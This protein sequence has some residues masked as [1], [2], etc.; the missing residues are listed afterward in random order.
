MKY[1]P[2]VFLAAF[3][4]LASSWCGLVLAP[5]L[6]LG[7]TTQTNAVGSVDLY[8]T[9]LPGLAHQGLEVYRANGCVYCH[10]QQ[11]TQDGADCELV[12]LAAGTNQPATIAAL[13]NVKP[14]LDDA[15]AKELLTQLP[16]T[17]LRTSSKTEADAATKQFDHTGAKLTTRIVPVGTDIARGWGLRR[18]VARDYLFQYPAQ[19]G[20]QRIG[21]D[22]ANVGVRLSDAKWHL[23]HLYNPTNVVAGS[24]MPSYP[25]LFEERELR[26]DEAPS[27]DALP[28]NV[29]DRVLLSG[30][31]FEI[32]PRPEARALVAYLVSLRADA[33]LFE[34]PFTPATAPAATVTNAPAAAPATNAPASAPATN[35]P[36]M[37]PATN[38]TVK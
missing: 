15:G 32:V 25:F 37:A 4:A 22:L 33:P 28:I 5:Q 11:V 29:A 10:S 31:K 16:Q 24:L 34:T 13:L 14:G 6:Q 7:S 38:A 27:P 21:P 8:P 9:A 18:S 26:P 23:L 12:L 3:F 17:I 36:A 2:L 1:G 20:E 35:V 19:L 30:G